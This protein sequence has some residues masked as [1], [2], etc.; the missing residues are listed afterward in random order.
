MKFITVFTPAFNR[1]YCLDRL[2]Q[3]LLVQTNKNFT[4]LV[5]DDGSTDN[6]KELVNNWIDEQKLD[7]QY[8][9]K[10]NGGMHT[11]HNAA[12][13]CIETELNVCID[14]DDY[15]PPNAIESIYDNWLKVKENSEIAGLIGLDQSIEGE[16]IGAKFINEFEPTTLADYYYRQGGKGD[17][18]LV[19]RSSHTNAYP[20]YP[21]FSDER[22]VPLDSLYILICRDYKL[23]PVNE[24]WVIVDYQPDGSSA[25]VIN[26]YFKSPK[27]FRYS[28]IV[29]MKY[30]VSFLQK[31]RNAVHYNISNL[32][33]GDLKLIFKSPNPLLTI[34]I[35]PISFAL[36]IY[37]KR[38]NVS[39]KVN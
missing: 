35:A 11:A 13:N 4:W 34:L 37:L 24:V 22:L 21:E 8:I 27:G 29:H 16:L 39:R 7:I 25:T 31:I 36:Y 1:A 3:S 19:L 17:K 26:Q 23:V 28:R 32:I 2:Y 20:R 12:Y 10:E 6:T 38:K 9:F 15:M 5:V 33:L 30:A 14:S 18:K